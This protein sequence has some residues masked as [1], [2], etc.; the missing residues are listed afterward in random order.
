MKFKDLKKIINEC[1]DEVLT[2]IETVG[3]VNIS[4]QDPL[5]QKKVDLAKKNKQSYSLYEKEELEEMADIYTN[6]KPIEKGATKTRGKAIEGGKEY[7]IFKAIESLKSKALKRAE[8]ELATTQS[9]LEE[10]EE[11]LSNFSG[12]RGMGDFVKN[13]IENKIEQLKQQVVKL[14]NKIKTGKIY[15]FSPAEIANEISPGAAQQTIFM[16][17]KKMAESGELIKINKNADVPSDF[18][19]QQFSEPENTEKSE[20]SEEEYT[21]PTK[22]DFE[23]V[24][25]DEITSSGEKEPSAK[26]L[27]KIEKELTFS[28][29][30]D[31]DEEELFE[32]TR[33][34]LQVRA[35][36]IK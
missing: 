1:V 31:E 25:D 9:D 16:D 19:H 4:S 32:D 24:E 14:D 35:G 18:K 11:K 17:L 27:A 8:I 12:G 23:T 10:E 33:H 13:N 5:K 6:A 30:D 22:N 3:A 20:D 2:E 26:D 15:F 28:D 34:I 29:E 21:T 36:I 7:R